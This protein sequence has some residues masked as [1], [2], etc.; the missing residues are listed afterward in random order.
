MVNWFDHWVGEYAK[1]RSSAITSWE[2]LSPPTQR[3]WRRYW[4]RHVYP[5]LIGGM[6]IGATFIAMFLCL[7]RDIPW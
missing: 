4:L 7:T 5:K 6:F 3:L 2:E 1:S